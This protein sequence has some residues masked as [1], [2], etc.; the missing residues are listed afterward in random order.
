ML[1]TVG[2]VAGVRSEERQEREDCHIET[3][4]RGWDASDERMKVSKYHMK[5][6]LACHAPSRRN[7]RAWT[8]TGV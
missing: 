1:S 8:R 4:T 3:R 2:Q 6:L 5:T 7:V